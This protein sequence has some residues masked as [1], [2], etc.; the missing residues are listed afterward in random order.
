MCEC[1]DLLLRYKDEI[2]EAEKTITDQR[3]LKK[4]EWHLSRA[5][6]NQVWNDRLSEIVTSANKL[7]IQPHS[8]L[9][10]NE[11]GPFL[12]FE[13]LKDLDFMNVF[14]DGPLLILAFPFYVNYAL[15]FLD[16]LTD[17]EAG[18]KRIFRCEECGIIGLGRPDQRFCSNQGRCR[19][20]FNNRKRNPEANRRAVREY[21]KEVAEG[22]GPRNKKGKE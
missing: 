15:A 2:Q 3:D 18:I 17:P 9:H 10:L 13:N 21:R 5:L 19:S 6:F 14:Q 11:K 22:Q 7:I 8:I 16:L 4:V 12:T 1:V 20:T